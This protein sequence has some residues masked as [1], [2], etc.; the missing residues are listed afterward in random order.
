MPPSPPPWSHDG[1]PCGTSRA[2][3]VFLSNAASLCRKKKREA[4]HQTW[5][6][7]DADTAL[8]WAAAINDSLKQQGRRRGRASGPGRRL[9][10]L[11]NPV[12]GTGDSR[13][14]WDKILRFAAGRAT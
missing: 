11:V 13:S 8:V 14:R 3:P 9:L 7:S 1:A 12:S 4:A 2:S 5:L 10:V 6:V